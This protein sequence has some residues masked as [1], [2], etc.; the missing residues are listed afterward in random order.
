MHFVDGW[1]KLL[2]HNLR[3]SIVTKMPFP[4]MSFS[5]GC[6]RT[7]NYFTFVHKFRQPYYF[8]NTSMCVHI[9]IYIYF[10][11][12]FFTFSLYVSIFYFAY[13]Q[14]IYL[15]S[16]NIKWDVT[17]CSLEESYLYVTTACCSHLKCS[18]RWRVKLQWMIQELI[19]SNQILQ[20]VDT[21]LNPVSLTNTF[22][23][24]KFYRVCYVFQ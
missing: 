19:L 18:S 6:A 7:F 5:W 17:P 10:F 12:N 14:R 21:C 20:V 2:W 22:D 4:R 24:I 3:L 9:H 1:W 13:I 8:I 15:L 23:K 11:L 16:Y